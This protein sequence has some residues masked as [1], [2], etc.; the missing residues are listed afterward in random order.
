M[1]TAAGCCVP[2]RIVAAVVD[3][4]GH[5]AAAAAAAAVVVVV[6]V[7]GRGRLPFDLQLLLLLRLLSS[8]LRSLRPSFFKPQSATL[9]SYYVAGDKSVGTYQ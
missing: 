6:V 9:Q 4:I 1:A 3:G 8:R 2:E 5:S 7:V